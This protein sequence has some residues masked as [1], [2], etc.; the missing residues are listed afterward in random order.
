MRSEVHRDIALLMTQM[1]R[2]CTIAVNKQLSLVGRS[3]PAYQVLF[4]LVHDEEVP[5][6]ELAFDAAIDPAALSRLIRDMVSEGLVTT[7]VD[8]TDKRQR[9][10]KATR[11]GRALE[12]TLRRIVDEALAPYM[13]GLTEEEEQEFVRLLRKAYRFVVSVATEGEEEAQ[14]EASRAGAPR[15]ARG[16]LLLLGGRKSGDQRR[17]LRGVLD[18][19][20]LVDD[21][22][23]HS[24]F[25]DAVVL[26]QV[27]V[28]LLL[29]AQAGEPLAR[30]LHLLVKKV[31]HL[32]PRRGALTT[33]SG[34]Q[35]FR[36]ARRR[37]LCRSQSPVASAS[38]E[39]L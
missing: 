22:E 36:T 35:R 38:G 25:R 13:G 15:E 32:A 28:E 5:Q 12:S 17:C 27:V 8:P 30:L 16:R 9:F 10:V 7:R 24:V 19:G 29:G 3:S 31:R 34:C 1:R 26:A 18:V 33:T 37:R 4:R 39:R 20:S 6:N 2:L 23:F 11:K 21:E 14:P